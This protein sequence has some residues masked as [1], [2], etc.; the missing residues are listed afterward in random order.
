MWG[1][2]LREMIDRA[3]T[4]ACVLR[5][6][7]FRPLRPPSRWPMGSLFS[8]P[9][10]AAR[11]GNSL[12]SGMMYPSDLVNWLGHF[13]RCCF[14]PSGCRSCRL[15]T[16]LLPAAIAL[17][18]VYVAYV[19]S[20][21]LYVLHACLQRLNSRA[22]AITTAATAAWLPSSFLGKLYCIGVHINRRRV[23]WLAVDHFYATLVLTHTL[24]L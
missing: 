18:A 15:S 8:S 20:Y 7:S 2:S 21:P 16:G 17:H 19:L 10:W 1:K 24:S 14:P 4:A 6:R 9:N 3:H 22:F 23:F 11:L 12:T 5:R 13:S